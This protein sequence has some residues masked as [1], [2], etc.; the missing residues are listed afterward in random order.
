MSLRA[1]DGIQEFAPLLGSDL[2]ETDAGYHFHVDLPGVALDDL[3]IQITDDKLSIMAERK[4]SHSDDNE[5]T[6]IIE[7][8]YGRLSRTLD[9]PAEADISTAKA[10]FKNGVLEVCFLKKNDFIKFKIP[11]TIS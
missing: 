7:R 3:N 8:V 1:G 6:H 4:K 5:F 2:I 11:I 9:L 10:S